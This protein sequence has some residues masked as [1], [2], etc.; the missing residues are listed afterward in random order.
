VLPIPRSRGTPAS[1]DMF[2]GVSILPDRSELG[3]DC[4]FGMGEILARPN[5]IR[6][7]LPPDS[8]DYPG[9]QR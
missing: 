3:T 4:G 5:A 1:A 7:E 9:C 2:S 8:A 6:R